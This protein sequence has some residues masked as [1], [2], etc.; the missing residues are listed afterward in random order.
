MNSRGI[1]KTRHMCGL[2]FVQARYA[3]A[4][5]ADRSRS[6]GKTEQAVKKVSMCILLLLPNMQSSGQKFSV[7]PITIKY[8]TNSKQP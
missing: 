2:V 4:L 1:D 8:S 6:I 7:K 3:N 5:M